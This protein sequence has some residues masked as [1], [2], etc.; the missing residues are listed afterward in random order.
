MRFLSTSSARR[1]TPAHQSVGGFG[2]FLST[3]SARRTTLQFG[4]RQRVKGISIHVLREEDDC[5][6]WAKAFGIWVF[7]STSSARRT[8][9]RRGKTYRIGNIS[10]HVLREE[11]DSKVAK[12]KMIKFGGNACWT[13]N[14]PMNASENCA[15]FRLCQHGM[16]IIRAILGANPQAWSCLLGIRTTDAG[17]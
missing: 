14:I 2:A 11:D 1:T 15:F 17:D 3:S 12:E 10:I 6:R 13:G 9:R 4:R 5:R 7:L 16:R 8:T